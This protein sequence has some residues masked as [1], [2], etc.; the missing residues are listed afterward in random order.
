MKKVKRVFK[1]LI[2]IFS[3]L[4]LLFFSGR[5]TFFIVDNFDIPKFLYEYDD[6]NDKQPTSWFLIIVCFVVVVFVGWLI[7]PMANR[8]NKTAKSKLPTTR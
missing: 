2:Y 1:W 8:V 5:F 7:Y 6:F 3:A 4:V